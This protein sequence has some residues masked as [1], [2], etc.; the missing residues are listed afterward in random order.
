[1]ATPVFI[2]GKLTTVTIGGTQF[3]GLTVSFDE[4]LSDLTDITY[5]VSGGATFGV[6]LPGYNIASGDITFVYDS[7]NQPVLAPQNMIPGTLMTLVVAPDGTKPFTM[8]AYSGKFHW[9]GGPRSGPVM[10]STH[11]QATGTFTRPSS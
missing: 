8:Q 7:A 11:Y 9:A 10:C 5:T 4:D 1:M 2:H 6:F 3:A